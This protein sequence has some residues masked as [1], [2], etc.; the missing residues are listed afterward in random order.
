LALAKNFT[1]FFHLGV[2]QDY[3]LKVFIQIWA[4]AYL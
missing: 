4:K 2:N 1:F 3:T